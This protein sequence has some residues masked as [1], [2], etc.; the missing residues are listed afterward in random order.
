MLDTHQTPDQAGFRPKYS[1]TEHLY[2]FRV[3]R[4]RA[5][6]WSQGLWIAAL[7]FK[8]AVDSVDNN[9]LWSSLASQYGQMATVRTEYTSTP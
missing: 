7:D 2:T 3:F 9:S 4:E 5:H 1:T 6:E 8:K